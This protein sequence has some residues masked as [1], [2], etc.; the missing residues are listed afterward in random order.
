MKERYLNAVR[1]LMDCPLED[2][3]RLL[4]RLGSAVTVYLED[5]PGAGETDLVANF[6]TPEDCAARLMEECRPAAVAAAR[7]KKDR[8]HRVLV[9]VLAAL[10]VI[11]LGIA[12]YLW[13]NG[14]LVIITTKDADPNEWENHPY[15]I[16]DYDDID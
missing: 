3:E 16:Y 9:S 7:R 13:A 2:R 12:A 11:A 4:S 5:T 8:R 1:R 14:G 6:G 15:V 10:L